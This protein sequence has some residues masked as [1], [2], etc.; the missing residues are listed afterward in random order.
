MHVCWQ[1]CPHRNRYN[2]IHEHKRFWLELCCSKQS[3]PCIWLL[4]ML[5]CRYPICDAMFVHSLCSTG[6]CCGKGNICMRCVL[7][8]FI[9][10]GK[11]DVGSIES[12][13]M[14]TAWLKYI[15]ITIIVAT[16][17]S[18]WIC[19]RARNGRQ[20]SFDG[21][22]LMICSWTKIHTGIIVDFLRM[23]ERMNTL[24]W[25]PFDGPPVF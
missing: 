25:G 15:Y 6:L 12:L 22:H 13:S 2:G 7:Y 24:E 9:T 17:M 23:A 14:E 19:E 11:L 5:W 1:C 3:S 8:M 10:N 21:S 16:I 4:A 18:I 20:L